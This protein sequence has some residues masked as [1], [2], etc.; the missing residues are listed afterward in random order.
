MNK[1]LILVLSIAFILTIS[2]SSRHR[3]QSTTTNN[4]VDL[5]SG[6][7]RDSNLRARDMQ[8]ESEHQ[9]T[10]RNLVVTPES[11]S[12]S[13]GSRA[14]GEMMSGMNFI[15]S[16]SHDCMVSHMQAVAAQ[17]SAV[18]YQRMIA[19]QSTLKFMQEYK[20]AGEIYRNINVQLQTLSAMVH[21]GNVHNRDFIKSN[22]AEL[23]TAYDGLCREFS[24]DRLDSAFKA[25]SDLAN[26]SAVAG[27]DLWGNPITHET[28]YQQLL[29]LEQY[30]IAAHH[31][32]NELN[33]LIDGLELA[34]YKKGG[35]F[36]EEPTKD[37]D[38]LIAIYQKQ[39]APGNNTMTEIEAYDQ[40]RFDRI[41]GHRS[42]V[43]MQS[44]K[45]HLKDGNLEAAEKVVRDYDSTLSQQKYK[46]P[47][48]ECLRT[49]PELNELGIPRI[50]AETNP[51]WHVY[52]EQ[53]L[54]CPGNKLAIAQQM[55]LEHVSAQD[56]C[57]Q[58]GIE[59][60]SSK[61]IQQAHLLLPYKND[62]VFLDH[63]GK[64][65]RDS[66]C[67]TNYIRI[68]EQRVD[69]RSCMQDAMRRY[70]NSARIFRA[71]GHE[72]LCY[73]GDPNFANIINKIACDP[74]RIQ[75]MRDNF[76]RRNDNVIALQRK[77]EYQEYPSPVMDIAYDLIDTQ[78]NA[79]QITR[80]GTLAI[81]GGNRE[82][83]QIYYDQDTHLPKIYTYDDTL[84]RDARAIAFPNE[85]GTQEYTSDRTLYAQ[86]MVQPIA[87][88]I[89]RQQAQQYLQILKPACN[90]HEH[91]DAYRALSH[92]A[93][94][95]YLNPAMQS[96]ET[97]QR[98]NIALCDDIKSSIEHGDIVTA[99]NNMAMLQQEMQNSDSTV[100]IPKHVQ[101]FIQQHATL[102]V[103]EMPHA[104]VHAESSNTHINNAVLHYDQLLTQV[105]AQH[106]AM[107]Q[108]NGALSEYFQ[109]R[110]NALATMVAGDLSIR[111]SS[112][113]LSP[114]AYKA[115]EKAG[116]DAEQFTTCTGN[117]LQQD[118]HAKLVN[119]LNTLAEARP[120][121][122]YGNVIRNGAFDCAQTG[123]ML[124]QAGHV[125]EAMSYA[126]LCTLVVEKALYLADSM[127]PL[128][129]GTRATLDVTKAL[130][131]A[132]SAHDLA[133]SLD[134][135]RSNVD[136]FRMGLA[137]GVIQGATDFKGI[138]DG[139][140]NTITTIKHFAEI[141]GD[142]FILAD[143]IEFGR[144]DEA[145][146]I[147]D[148]NHERYVR[149]T[150][151]ANH[152]AQQVAAFVEHIPDMTPQEWR[153]A[154][155]STGQFTGR[156]AMQFGAIKAG[157]SGLSKLT[158]GV[159]QAAQNFDAMAKELVISAHFGGSPATAAQVAANIYRTEQV[160]QYE[161][162]RF[163]NAVTNPESVSRVILNES[164]QV[165]QLGTQVVAE[166]SNVTSHAAALME[167]GKQLGQTL[168]SA[169]PGFLQLPG[170]SAET[171]SSTEVGPCSSSSGQAECLPATRIVSQ[172]D[173]K[174]FLNEIKD[175]ELRAKVRQYLHEYDE[176][177]KIVCA[178]HGKHTIGG[179]H[180]FKDHQEGWHET[181]P[182][183]LQHEILA[184]PF[185][186]TMQTP[187][188]HDLPVRKP[189]VM[190]Y[191]HI[192]TPELLTKCAKGE[193]SGAG[194]HHDYMRAI[195]E[196]GLIE[197]KDRV[198]LPNGCYQFEWRS[199]G[200]KFKQ[201][202]MFPAEW[203]RAQTIEKIYES[204]L[205]AN[206][207]AIIYENKILSN[208]MPNNKYTHL[209]LTTEGI[210][211]VTVIKVGDTSAR[212]IT[213]YPN[214]ELYKLWLEGK[215]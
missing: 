92:F 197:I 206:T 202:T 62:T 179:R 45:R 47:V 39:Y 146:R 215:I 210:P 103:A 78:N 6:F 178:Q 61:Q 108:Q 19:H 74:S 115:L 72:L 164:G 31:L 133:Q 151:G 162:T 84:I 198:T 136:Q 161:G 192:T 181:V 118:T 203:T 53:L 40:A 80:L 20:P 184:K 120:L 211:I 160:A 135:L 10:Q 134:T 86:V 83:Y 67:F 201:S 51:R 114:H 105:Q 104:N 182:G 200:S 59:N 116:I 159:V 117:A 27:Y 73:A 58:V 22:F 140:C 46:R 204:M 199:H 4:L 165:A 126:D 131:H 17:R 194:F 13:Q 213:A 76:V 128:V 102:A 34:L 3:E 64:A 100:T 11:I 56:L 191:E 65:L 170:S 124:N 152:L 35:G 82:I 166:S 141:V 190:N 174:A 149:I 33:N 9:I 187:V 18:S 169:Q 97:M 75:E 88:D 130:L 41:K 110:E 91:Q 99:A 167:L 176:K 143:A 52:K 37:F 44:I 77:L 119:T 145:R 16:M 144:Y 69:A 96:T 95:I 177:Q 186:Y 172:A 139:L 21:A 156:E 189:I 1:K 66:K 71:R 127:S 150:T 111:E 68:F 60:A 94:Q 5:W 171:S 113:T 36:L 101:D 106:V 90:A 7:S 38:A 168:S 180:A 148:A 212:V 24:Q 49:N 43:A 14:G 208:G 107:F 98:Q 163:I 42:N 85:L 158:Q 209:G 79:E 195:E 155:V 132:V 12:R 183:D 50:C 154:G 193:I 55:Y 112:Y 8:T 142:Q 57:K 196:S 207:K 15:R 125:L 188:H 122:S 25:Y 175:P 29:T 157:I 70:P 185:D 93:G 63:A 123:N 81:D 2:P 87:S 30:T 214:F 28:S 48:R 205:P 138:Y 32:K 147:L 23:R 153:Q 54:A 137:V 129:A 121:S 109:S 89:H 26:N 173:R